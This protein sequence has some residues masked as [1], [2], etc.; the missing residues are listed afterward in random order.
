M[1]TLDIPTDQLLSRAQIRALVPVADAMI[2]R[3][4]AQGKFPEHVSISKRNYWRRSEVAAWLN[5]HFAVVE[6]G[7]V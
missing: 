5:S 4:E 3:W 1:S 7:N 2:W 6:D